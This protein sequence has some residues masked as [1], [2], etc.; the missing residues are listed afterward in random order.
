MFGLRQGS[1][2]AIAPGKRPLS[3]MAPTVVLRGGRLVMVLG[4]PNGSRII[5]VVL[6]VLINVIDYRMSLADAVTAPRV[7]EQY[8]PDVLFTEP[9]ALSPAV[10][11]S[12]QHMGYR[13]QIIPPFGAAEVIESVGGKWSGFNDPRSPDGSAACE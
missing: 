8:M 5:S 2:N 7:H 3:S 10:Q 4:S 6:Q 12:L 9:G 13:L 1:R 11:A